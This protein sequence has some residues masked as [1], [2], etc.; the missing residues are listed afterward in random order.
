MNISAA[1]NAHFLLLYPW[2]KRENQPH[3][4]ATSAVVSSVS[5]LVKAVVAATMHISRY[6]GV[7]CIF[8]FVTVTHFHILSHGADNESY[9][10]GSKRHQ[11]FLNLFSVIRFSNTPCMAN[12]GINGTCYTKKECGK[13]G[14]TLAG[15][16][17]GG[18]GV[19]CT[20]SLGC[21]AMTREN[22]T[23]LSTD[24]SSSSCV[25]TICKCNPEVTFLR[26][27]FTEFDIAQPFTC[28]SSST[29]VQC[30]ISD[31]PLIGDCIYDSFTVT[32]P[33]VLGLSCPDEE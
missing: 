19:C 8:A 9:E 11:K 5:Q 15:S 25:Y 14:G 24:V 30:G 28:G 21:G 23:Y 17:A 27:D 7:G 1:L 18:F 4:A 12:S 20:F 6:Y 31:G 2:P 16:C 33:I 26:L 3:I 32:T 10:G 13:R 29:P 22:C